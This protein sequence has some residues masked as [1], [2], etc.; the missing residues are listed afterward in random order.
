M[1]CLTGTNA[2]R[3]ESMNAREMLLAWIDRFENDHYMSMLAGCLRWKRRNRPYNSYDH[4]HR[5]Q[6][7]G[8]QHYLKQENVIKLTLPILNNFSASSSPFHPR[9]QS[10]SSFGWLKSGGSG[11][12]I[13]W[14]P[15]M[16]AKAMPVNGSPKRSWPS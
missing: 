16:N 7:Q 6:E 12:L 9:R 14:L 8:T 13:A 3:N 4:I 1:I 5:R 2:E 10:L 15:L 11:L